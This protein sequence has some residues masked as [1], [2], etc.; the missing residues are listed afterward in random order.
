MKLKRFLLRYFPPGI[1]L[2]YE[3]SGSLHSR[4]IDLLDLHVDTNIGELAADIISNDPLLSSSRMDQIIS[5]LKKLQDKLASSCKPH[6]YLFKVIK[7]HMLP[8][9]N[10][11]FN[12]SGSCF[13]T[14][15]Y[16]RTCKI[17]ETGSGEE[18]MTLEGH[19]NVVYALA[20]NNPYG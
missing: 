18:L 15:S 9:T 16:D 2:E 3:H 6:Y 13:I 19:K 10:L 20:F 11:A 14:G 8:L 1:I 5:L 4:S 7:A 17:W 12:K